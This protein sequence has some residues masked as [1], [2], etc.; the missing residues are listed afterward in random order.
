MNIRLYYQMVGDDGDFTVTNEIGGFDYRQQL[1]NLKMPVLIIAGRYDRVAVPW[2]SVQY[3]DFC[4]QARFVMFERSGHN[5]FVEEP[6]KTFRLI[7]Q[8]LAE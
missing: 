2:M 6:E 4:P 8:F 5:T 1:K 3:K 7:Q